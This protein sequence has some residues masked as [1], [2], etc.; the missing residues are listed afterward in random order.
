MML[1]IYWSV[2]SNDSQKQKSKQNWILSTDEFLQMLWFA[3]LLVP[4]LIQ[5]AS[6][7]IWL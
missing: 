4:V 2:I 3:L 6:W 1:E 7:E 5:D